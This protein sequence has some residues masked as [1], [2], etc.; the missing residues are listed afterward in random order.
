MTEAVRLWLEQGRDCIRLWLEGGV[1]HPGELARES[2]AAWRQGCADAGWSDMA[3]L[4]EILLD[5]KQ[6]DESRAAALLQLCTC[7]EVLRSEF[8]RF[9]ILEEYSV[10]CQKPVR[11]EFP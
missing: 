11:K 4:G 8:G 10:P 9:M 3:A 7:Y 5:E 6:P 2:L 1:A